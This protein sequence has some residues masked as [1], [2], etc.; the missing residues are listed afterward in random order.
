MQCPKCRRMIHDQAAMCEYCGATI[1]HSQTTSQSTA[2]VVKAENTVSGI[3]GAFLGS[4]LGGA[5]I[6]LFDQL[7]YVAAL[8]GIILAVCTL[9]GYELLGGRLSKK[10]VLISI[11]LMLVIPYFANQV[12]SAISFVSYVADSGDKISFA[13]AFQAVPQL[14]E[15]AGFD[16]GMYNYTLDSGANT[17]GLVMI[18]GFA[19]LGAFSTVRSAFKKK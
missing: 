6:V 12:S 4:L 19:L 3:V 15:P 8:S 18:Y 13:Q 11:A 10:G 14:M 16:Y 5:S 9:K 7:G 1:D 17:T 2:P